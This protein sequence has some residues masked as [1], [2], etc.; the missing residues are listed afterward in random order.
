MQGL[1][2]ADEIHNS[3]KTMEKRKF[4]IFRLGEAGIRLGRSSEWYRVLDVRLFISQL[5]CSDYIDG[6]PQ[7][8][9]VV[10][11]IGYK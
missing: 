7:N 1:P 5:I 9:S 2:R 10:G 3:K 6:P 11:G 4:H 8:L